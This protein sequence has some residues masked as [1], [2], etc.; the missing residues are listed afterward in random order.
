METTER[1]VIYLSAEEIT[2]RNKEIILKTGGC[3][4]AAGIPLN[5]N[6]L[7]YL[8]GI[9]EEGIA[10]YQPYSTLSQKA[11]VYTFNII[12]KHIFVDGNKRTGM[13]CALFFLELNG[14]ILNATDDEIVNV[15]KSIAESKIDFQ[16]TVTWIE[17]RI[18][19]KVF[20]LTFQSI[21]NFFYSFPSC[22]WEC[23]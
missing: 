19:P 10:G 13:T 8:V 17:E 16:Q 20:E 3:S 4:A 15:A 2:R 18:Q 7:K 11:A 14:Y 22:T 12:K 6:S 21:C 5:Y 1:N 23:K 9:V